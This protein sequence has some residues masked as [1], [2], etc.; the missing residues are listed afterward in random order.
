MGDAAVRGPVGPPVGQPAAEQDESGGSVALP[1]VRLQ[2]L[3]H[4]FVGAAP[5][6][7]EG[8]ADLYGQ[9]KITEGQGVGAPRVRCSVSA[10]VQGPMP[11][12]SWSRA[13]ASGS[14]M[15]AASSRRG[16]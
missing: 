12:M 15:A 3:K 14:S 6:A 5:G 4:L 10:A 11:G 7:G 13:I 8:V 2:Q 16:A 1:G 9:V